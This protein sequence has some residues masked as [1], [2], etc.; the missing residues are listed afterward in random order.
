[1]Y[2]RDYF[3]YIKT[4]NLP[5]IKVLNAS[6]CDFKYIRHSHNDYAIGITT[7][8][9]QSF[10]CSGSYYK[11]HRGGIILFNPEE[12]HDGY[13]EDKAGFS[14]QMIYIPRIFFIDSLKEIC[15]KSIR[16][17]SFKQ[18]VVFDNAVRNKLLSF[19]SA[20]NTRGKDSF[21]VNEFFVEMIETLFYKNSG[22]LLNEDITLKK[23]SLIIKATNLIDETLQQ[24][25]TL[26]DICR[27][28]NISKYHFIRMFKKQVGMTPYQYMLDSKIKLACEDLETGVDILDIVERYGFYDLSHF[29]KRFK[30]VFGLTPS[31][32][33]KYMVLKV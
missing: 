7:S 14:Y 28:L 22:S 25:I 9:H 5:E 29:G 21:I 16:D 26:N 11:V 6:I 18:T 33:R 10:F 4:P 20:V 19:I 3:S 15:N 32:Y 27:E 13:N 1:M 12:L 24:Q 2:A 17:F 8:G 31:E 30:R 23:D